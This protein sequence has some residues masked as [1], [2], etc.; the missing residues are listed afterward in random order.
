[1]L[2]FGIWIHV[3]GARVYNETQTQSF[4]KGMVFSKNVYLQANES[5]NNIYQKL[6]NCNTA[7][8]TVPV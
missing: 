7:L 5:S 1:M 2:P 3:K 8:E 4:L 6:I